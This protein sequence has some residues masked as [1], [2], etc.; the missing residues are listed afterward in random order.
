M[1]QDL[2]L[3]GLWMGQDLLHGLWMGQDLLQL[4][5][6]LEQKAQE[7]DAPEGVDLRSML[8]RGPVKVSDEPLAQ[9]RLN[10][11]AVFIVEYALAQL[12]MSWGIIPQALIGYSVG[13]YVAA[14]LAGVM[15]LDDAL[16]LLVKR[17][18]LI[19]Q[20]PAGAMLA[21]PLP[22][23]QIE[24]L[25]EEHSQ[26]S[27]AIV[28]TPNQCVVGGPPEAIAELEKNCVVDHFSALLWP[29]WLFVA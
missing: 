11:P 1:G 28:S 22:A 9:T 4:L 23:E 10:Q 21:V 12:W 29:I 8:K 15:S 19:D 7:G 6:P 18:G 27:L 14:C 5:Y 20:Q 2:M 26:L 16:A 3:H 13:E 17:A 25:L 24:S